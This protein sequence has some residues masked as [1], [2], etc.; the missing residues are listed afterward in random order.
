M[1]MK[2]KAERIC[3]IAFFWDPRMNFLI[4]RE[5]KRFELKRFY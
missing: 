1:V 4:S 3:E 2:A 5:Q